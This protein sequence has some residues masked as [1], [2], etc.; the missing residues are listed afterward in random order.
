MV[1]LVTY[2]DKEVFFKPENEYVW[3]GK[4]DNTT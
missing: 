3:S 2:N 1:L 4:P